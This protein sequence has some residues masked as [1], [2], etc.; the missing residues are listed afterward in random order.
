MNP[1]SNPKLQSL[2][3]AFFS[4]TST[5]SAFARGLADPAAP[6]SLS[7]A[8]ILS[9]YGLFDSETQEE[10]RYDALWA[11]AR[12]H[13]T[14]VKLEKKAEKKKGSGKKTTAAEERGGED[15]KPSSPPPPSSAARTQLPAPPTLAY[16][17][18]WN[19]RGFE[20]ALK[21]HKK[22]T[23]VSPVWYQIV[24]GPP[25]GERGERGGVGPVL[26]GGEGVDARWLAEMRKR[27]PG[28][29]ILPRVSLELD[30]FALALLFGGAASHAL[31]VG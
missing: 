25:G 27:A 6:S 31:S 14:K 10:R 30:R 19:P 8:T 2:K 17:T 23:H 12:A 1:L 15:K 5:S 24:A 29:K 21:F 28:T 18:P 11:E 16:V 13:A 7:A 20:A 3:T 9:N 4:S 22:L 26:K